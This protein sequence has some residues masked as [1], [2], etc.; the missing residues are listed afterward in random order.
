MK[1]ETVKIN[2]YKDSRRGGDVISFDGHQTL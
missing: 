1:Y 2:N